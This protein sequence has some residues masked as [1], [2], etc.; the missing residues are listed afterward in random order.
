MGSII[1]HNCKG[2]LFVIDGTDG[3]GKHTQAEMLYKYLI[4]YYSLE[5]EKDIAMVSFPRYDTPGCTMVKK[6]LNG[7]FGNDPNMVDPYTAS[8]FYTIDRSISFKTENW[9]NVYRNG[10][11]VI[12]DRYYT[13]NIIHQGAKI[14][15]TTNNADAKGKYYLTA[16]GKF[17]KLKEWLYKTEIYCIGLPDPDKI[18]WL[19][20]DAHANDIMMQHRVEVDSTHVTDIHESNKTYLDWCRTALKSY[21]EEYEFT[22]SMKEHIDCVLSSPL[23]YIRREEFINVLN[24]NNELRTIQ[25]ISEEIADYTRKVLVYDSECG[26]NS[27]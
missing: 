20:A 25:E 7:E 19:I 21:Q 16:N 11:I 2:H 17:N 18:F 15:S 24:S 12:A 5:P 6:Y 27:N 13:S 3:S 22:H 1:N 26:D 14:F 8:M 23:R 4:D 9:G 10:G